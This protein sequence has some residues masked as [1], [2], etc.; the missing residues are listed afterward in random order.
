METGRPIAYSLEEN[1]V[2]NPAGAMLALLHAYRFD[3]SQGPAADETLDG[4]KGRGERH[5]DKVFKVLE[6]GGVDAK[7]LLTTPRLV[8]DLLSETERFSGAPADIAVG[9]GRVLEQLGCSLK[10][11]KLAGKSKIPGQEKLQTDGC[12]GFRVKINDTYWVFVPGFSAP[13]AL[14]VDGR[15]HEI[16][17]LS[18]KVEPLFKPEKDPAIQ[19]EKRASFAGKYLEMLTKTKVSACLDGSVIKIGNEEKPD[20]VHRTLSTTPMSP[21]KMIETRM[22]FQASQIDSNTTYRAFEISA[23][24]D[25]T[26]FIRMSEQ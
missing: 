16:V 3:R 4:Y 7:K 23:K 25:N 15:L 5:A 10:Y 11:L 9:M 13:L 20:V 19:T 6:K 14:P 8:R 17:G 26:T 22:S 18:D 12:Y 2:G 21:A 24:D 1:P